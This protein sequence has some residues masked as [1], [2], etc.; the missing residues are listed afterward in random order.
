MAAKDRRIAGGHPMFLDAEA[1]E[2]C[3]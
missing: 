1:Y 3:I 2:R